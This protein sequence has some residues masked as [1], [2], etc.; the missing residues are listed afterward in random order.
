MNI[1]VVIISHL[2]D[3]IEFYFL[4]GSDRAR[5]SCYDLGGGQCDQYVYSK[6][7]VK[8]HGA[9]QR[10][11]SVLLPLESASFLTDQ[12]EAPWIQATQHSY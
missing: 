10:R 9:V 4:L 5:L 2:H 11:G 12:L 6:E 3:L 7:D 1:Y 8:M